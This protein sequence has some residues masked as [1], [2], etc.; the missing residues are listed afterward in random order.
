M[1]WNVSVEGTTV[2]TTTCDIKYVNEHKDD[3]TLQCGNA[4]ITR[5]RDYT[6]FEQDGI[7]WFFR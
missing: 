5:M 2:A 7:E 4:T 3:R 6:S 1:T